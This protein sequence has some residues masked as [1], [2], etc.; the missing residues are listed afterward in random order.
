M[1]NEELLKQYDKIMRLN[2]YL[3]EKYG[4]DLWKDFG[5]EMKGGYMT[6]M[7][8]VNKILNEIYEQEKKKYPKMWYEYSLI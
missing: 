1:N 5:I 8:T 3:L 2:Y 4:K 7:I 6:D